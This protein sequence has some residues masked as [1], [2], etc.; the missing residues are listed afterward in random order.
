MSVNEKPQQEDGPIVVTEKFSGTGCEVKEPGIKSEGPYES[1]STYLEN[2]IESKSKSIVRASDEAHANSAGHN[3]A[4]DKLIFELRG[5]DRKWKEVQQMFESRTGRHLSHKVLRNRCKVA[6]RRIET[7]F[8]RRTFEEQEAGDYQ[9]KSN[10]AA[11][12]DLK[13]EPNIPKNNLKIEKKQLKEEQTTVESSANCGRTGSKSWNSQSFQAYLKAMAETVEDDEMEVAEASSVDMS[14][15]KQESSRCDSPITDE[16][17]CHWAYHVKRK[18]WITSDS[19]GADDEDEDDDRMDPEAL[20]DWYVVGASSY[21]SLQQANYAAGQEVFRERD[22][23]ALGPDVRQWSYRLN[24]DD[25]AEYCGTMHDNRRHFRV[26]VDRFLRNPAQGVL[27]ASKAGWLSKRV[28]EI[29]QRVAKVKAGLD[30]TDSVDEANKKPKPLPMV[31]VEEE[32]EDDDDGDET[33]L[34]GLY[35]ILDQANREAGRRV[36]EMTTKPNSTRIDDQLSRVEVQKEMRERLDSLEASNS[37]FSHTARLSNGH[38]SGGYVD[39]TIWVEQ[40]ELKGPR[41]I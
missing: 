14:T 13:S 35:T 9:K 28:Y 24:D 30:M 41:N 21:S 1:R 17:V 36:L 4:D 5:K 2:D 10:T 27:P 19:D 31:T 40:R 15:P 26:V 3:P 12:E 38:S 23:C 22:C 34:D 32:E 37:L 11:K 39:V 33:V 20:A 29:K 18:T 8:H 16:D 25:M 7:D 6:A